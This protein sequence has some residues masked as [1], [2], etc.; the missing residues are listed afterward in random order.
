MRVRIKI[1]LC[2]LLALFAI[3]SLGA[4]L[5]GLGLLPEEDVSASAEQ[6]YL[7]REW[8]GCVG[9]F[10]PPDAQSP[11]MVTDIQVRGLPISDRISLAS[12]IA[13]EDYGGV[14]RLLEDF[15]S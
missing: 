1:I 14:I 5:A 12:G 4:V 2:V 11:V 7:L 13:A 9:V 3:A 15:G 6:G 10:C 8:D